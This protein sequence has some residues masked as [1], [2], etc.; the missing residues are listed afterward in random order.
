MST[1]STKGG[2]YERAQKKY[3]LSDGK[4]L[5]T[6]SF[7]DRKRLEA[8]VGDGALARYKVFLVYSTRASKAWCTALMINTSFLRTC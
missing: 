2:L 5:F 8:Q 3:K 4:M 1:F 6:Y 7:F